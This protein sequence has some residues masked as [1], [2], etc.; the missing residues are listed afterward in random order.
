MDLVIRGLFICEYANSHLKYWSKR[1]NF[2]LKRVFLSV[3]SVF[4]V[5]NIGADNKVHL[6]PKVKGPL[7]VPAAVPLHR[8]VAVSTPQV[9]GH[10]WR[11]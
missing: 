3:N 10:V 7:P 11:I 6:Y 2:K 9:V 4:A 5:Q 8:H 1:P